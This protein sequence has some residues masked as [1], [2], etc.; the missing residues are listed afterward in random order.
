MDGGSPVGDGSPIGYLIT[1]LLLILGGGYFAGAE[2]A[3]ASCSRI[4]MMNYAEDGDKRAKRVLYLLDHFDKALTTLLIGNNLMHI[5]CAS[6]ATLV[7][8][9]LWGEGATAA[10]SIITTLVVFLLSEMIP[11]AFA[12]DCSE[13]F[14]L[15]VSQSLRVL[16]WLLTP[17]TAVFSAIGK[18]AQKPFGGEPEEE[19][20]VSED[21]LHELIENMDEAG[22][23]SED[24]TELVQNALEFTETPARN[25]VTPWNKVV[26]LSLDMDPETVRRTVFEHHLSRYP[27][28][29]SE[30]RV[31]GLLQTRK[32]LRA[33][34]SGRRADLTR[35]M[36]EC[37]FVPEGIPLD[38]LLDELTKHRVH[39]AV[40][41][42]SEGRNLG[43]VTIEDLL[44]ELVGEIYD[45]EDARGGA[46]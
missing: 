11:K 23:I 45:E 35:L 25:V 39:L 33:L 28:V 43:I 13:R 41:R 27:V 34:E 14:A 12:S 38:E 1:F 24:A 21:E 2:T 16:M 6:L 44:E 22:D 4:R 7:A 18:L 17:L 46:R 15:A 19:P 3:L 26:T 40:V 9:R 36:G 32:Y 20:T 30:G 37:R 29:D 10:T 31:A 8:L 5:G 42:D